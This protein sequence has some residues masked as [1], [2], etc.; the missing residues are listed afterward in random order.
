MG[1]IDALAV[2]PDGRLLATAKGRVITLWELNTG[3]QVATLEGH[4]QPV[5]RLTFAP[6]G[7]VL[8]SAA[9]VGRHPGR[10]TDVEVKVW[11]LATKQPRVGF[12]GREKAVATLGREWAGRIRLRYVG[13]LPP[14]SFTGERKAAWA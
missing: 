6:D 10:F 11:D 12:H 2:S 5:T 9:H 14:Y 1:A 8:A 13:P 3:K 7:A 4:M